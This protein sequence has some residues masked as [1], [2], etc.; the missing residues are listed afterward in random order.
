[1][2]QKKRVKKYYKPK[3]IYNNIFTIKINIII[4]IILIITYINIIYNNK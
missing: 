3:A 1:M 4:L 2:S